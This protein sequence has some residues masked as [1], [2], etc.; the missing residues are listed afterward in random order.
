[1]N[2]N[3]DCIHLKY[4]YLKVLNFFSL[5]IEQRPVYDK[6]D[7]KQIIPFWGCSPNCASYKS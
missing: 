6:C 1:M 5:E 2:L 3:K 7:I 4:R